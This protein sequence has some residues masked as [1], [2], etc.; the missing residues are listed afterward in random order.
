MKNERVKLYV[1]QLKDGRFQFRLRYVDPRSGKTHRV[2]CIKSSNSRQAYNEALRELQDRALEAHMERPTLDQALLLYLEDK[3]RILRPQTVIRNEAEIRRVNAAIGPLYLDKLTV[4]DIKRAISAISEKNCT[5]NERQARYKAF[6]NWCYQ[7]ELLKVNLGDKLVPLPDNKKERIQDK[8]L[9]PEQLKALL[10]AIKP[11]LWNHLTVFLVLSGLRIGEAIAL[12][13]E[14]VGER[15]ITVNKTYSLITHEV[16]DTKTDT[17]ARE[18]YIQPELRDAIDRYLIFRSGYQ[19][20]SPYFFPGRSGGVMVYGSYDKFLREI[21]GRVL[22]RPISPHA[23]RHT[24]ASLL[25]ASGVSV[26]AISRRLG[27]A[28][29]KVTKEIYL[30]MTSKLKAA[31][32]MAIGNAT[33]L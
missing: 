22:G 2:S 25:L 9:E 16:G 6:L 20:R 32:E 8:Y 1:E 11:P 7:N 26:D 13:M 27:H 28:D 29:S 3:K 21:S 5:Y 4:M 24:S 15:Y 14:D 12:R 18:V 23:L 33:L 31:D 17:S 10:D 19:K 30:H